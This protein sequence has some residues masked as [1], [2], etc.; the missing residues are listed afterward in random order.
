MGAICLERDR[1]VE[2]AAGLRP[3]TILP[4]NVR[5]ST[6]LQSFVF[7]PSQRKQLLNCI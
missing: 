5:S 2:L 3:S 4:A 1:P 6:S 7:H